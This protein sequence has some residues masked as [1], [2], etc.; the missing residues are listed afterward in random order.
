MHTVKFCGKKE[1]KNSKK[2]KLG[3]PYFPWKGLIL[4][5][6]VSYLEKSYE[7]G[8]MGMGPPHY[9]P[10]GYAQGTDGLQDPLVPEGRDLL[11]ESERFKYYSGCHSFMGHL[12]LGGFK[13]L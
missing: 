13:S 2:P 3:L 9:G 1:V 10:G 6:N 4:S 7:K 11:K 5:G 8:L 12:F